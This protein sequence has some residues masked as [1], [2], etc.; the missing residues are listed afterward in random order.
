MTYRSAATIICFAGLA[1]L[2]SVS[3]IAGPIAS[4]NTSFTV[5]SIQE[6]TLLQLPF[7]AFAGDVILTE[8]GG[9]VTSDVFRIFNNIVNTGAGTGLG[10][11]VFL[12]SRDDNT[13]PLPST[14]SV[15]AVF[16]PENPS[17]ITSYL[18][19]G[20]TYQLGAPEPR[21]L[22]LLGLALSAMAVLARKRSKTS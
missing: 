8:S 10:N 11:M 17:G 22:E 2:P 13:L 19:N 16:I 5:C 20:T 9:A 18:G 21:T 7:D 3:A 6:N 4:C 1:L 12:Y 14:Y 15:N